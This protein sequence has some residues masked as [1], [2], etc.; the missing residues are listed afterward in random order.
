MIQRQDLQS[1]LARI[2]QTSGDKTLLDAAEQ[3]HK[4]DEIDREIKAL[5]V[6]GYI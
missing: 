3:S 1:Q 5:E 6:C 4:I 2:Q